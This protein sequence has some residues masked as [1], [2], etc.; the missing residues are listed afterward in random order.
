L[1]FLL[2]IPLNRIYVGAID[3]L[4]H[5][6]FSL[7]SY[8]LVIPSRHEL[9]YQTFSLV[10]LAALLLAVRDIAL[11]ARMRWL[12]Y[13]LFSM[14]LVQF[15]FRLCNVWIK[16]FQIEWI[17][18]ISQVIYITCVYALPFLIAL[19]FWMRVPV[20]RPAAYHKKPG[21]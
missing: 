14:T 12:A 3:E 10:A 5:R 2:W 17:T 6:L 4:I 19:I 18:P 8:T 20:G 7:G 13:G 21:P 11:S 15:A 9:Y 1:L 16:A